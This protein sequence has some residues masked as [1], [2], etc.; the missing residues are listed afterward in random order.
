MIINVV[1]YLIVGV[2]EEIDKFF[3]R[4][5]E[6]GFLEFLSISGKKHIE[7]PIPIQSLLAAIKILRK[8]PVGEIYFG[9][10]DLPFAM[11]IS[12]RILELKEDLEKLHEEQRLLEAEISRVAPFGDFSM[13]DLEYVEREGERKLQFFCRKA[14]KDHM[15]PPDTDLIYVATEYGLDYFFQLAKTFLSTQA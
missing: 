8:F 14:T 2:K 9:G 11:Q 5:Q 3:E 12:E 6:H 7:Q 15:V 1:K 10:G 4:A 13:E